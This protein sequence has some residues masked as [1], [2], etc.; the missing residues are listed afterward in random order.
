MKAVCDINEIGYMHD[1]GVAHKVRVVNRTLVYHSPDASMDDLYLY[2][3]CDVN[4]NEMLKT[5][6]LFTISET[7]ECIEQFYN[8]EMAC[9]K[10]RIRMQNC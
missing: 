6:F 10:K 1:C 7:R 3:V 8:E 4:T 2:D 9:E 5:A